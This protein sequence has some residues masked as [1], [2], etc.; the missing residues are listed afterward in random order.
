MFSCRACDGK[1][2]LFLYCTESLI[3]E[4]IMS[5]TS[6]NTSRTEFNSSKYS[7]A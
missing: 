7:K 4:K 6:K 1:D 3:E 2:R 5:D